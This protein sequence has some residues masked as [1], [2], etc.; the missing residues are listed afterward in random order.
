MECIDRVTEWL[1]WHLSNFEYVWSWALWSKHLHEDPSSVSQVKRNF[2]TDLLDKCIRLSSYDAIKAA[3]P[4]SLHEF[5]PPQPA[6]AP[7]PSVYECP[8]LCR[9]FEAG[10]MQEAA[11]YVSERKPAPDTV[12]KVALALLSEGRVVSF[13]NCID[14]L[15]SAGVTDELALSCLHEC[16]P[17]LQYLSFAIAVLVEKKL[18][19]PLAATKWLF[20]DASAQVLCR[21]AAWD[22][23]RKLMAEM[24]AS[25]ASAESSSASGMDMDCSETDASAA[26][27]HILQ[28]VLDT[29]NGEL[30]DASGNNSKSY[31]STT[32]SEHAIEF[33][34]KYSKH[35]SS[36]TSELISQLSCI[37]ERLS[38]Y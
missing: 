33:V 23:A 27:H 30:P 2:V 10:D 34:R 18:V 35:F 19:A 31:L 5:L 11:R 16:C 3:T 29:A 7:S 21:S 37:D 8:E 14:V 15:R 36:D 17:S 22:I 20:S 28:F 26:V 1:S 32:V 38:D 4:E 12:L 24:A 9:A 6:L 13:M 25:A